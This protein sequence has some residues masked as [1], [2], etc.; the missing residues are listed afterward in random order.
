MLERD[1]A[2]LGEAD[3][4]RFG[5]GALPASL[6]D[7]LEALAGDETARGWLAPLLYDA[8]VAVKRA[9]LDGASRAGARRAL[10]A[11]CRD[12]LSRC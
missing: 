1:P 5:V 6:A 3:A 7:A 10:R 2:E 4:E 11:L 9:E 8:Y 12:L